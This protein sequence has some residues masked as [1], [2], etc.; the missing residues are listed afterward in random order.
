MLVVKAAAGKVKLKSLRRPGRAS[1]RFVIPN[2]AISVRSST[3]SLHS[4]VSL[5]TVA[6]FTV[7]YHNTISLPRRLTSLDHCTTLAPKVSFDTAT[8]T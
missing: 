4:E 7:L 2:K 5:H 6:G 8:V 1:P 3:R